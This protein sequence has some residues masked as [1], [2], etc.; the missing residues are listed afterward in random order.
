[1][2]WK[3]A[4]CDDDA[5]QAAQLQADVTDWAHGA[6]AVTCFL[7]SSASAALEGSFLAWPISAPI[8][9]DS[10]L[11]LARRSLASP[12]AARYSASSLMT[13]STR[14]SLAS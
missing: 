3:I 9:L 10:L 13:S 5:G 14:G 8:C 1:M 2:G 11:R 6:C 12:M 7:I 4:I